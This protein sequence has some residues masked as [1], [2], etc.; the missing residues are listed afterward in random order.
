MKI[1]KESRASRL[2]KL[3]KPLSGDPGGCR[4]R[5]ERPAVVTGRRPAWRR[6]GHPSHPHRNKFDGE[7][8]ALA[9]AHGTGREKRGGPKPKV[10]AR[11]PRTDVIRVGN[12]YG[13][14]TQGTMGFWQTFLINSWILELT[15][16]GLLDQV[17]AE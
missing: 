9:L 11:R 17:L 15:A 14:E 8:L 1:M 10:P 3:L 4:C 6:R 13:T 16:V 12:R 7:W 5:R 2:H